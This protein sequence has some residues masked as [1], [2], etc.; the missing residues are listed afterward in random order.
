MK[1]VITKSDTISTHNR[2]IKTI[3]S[4]TS[5]KTAKINAYILFTSEVMFLC[6]MAVS[7]FK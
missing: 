3:P 2:Q 7:E 1:T 5:C 6:I 4:E